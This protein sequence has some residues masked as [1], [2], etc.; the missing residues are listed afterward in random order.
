[1]NEPTAPFKR[2][3]YNLR[4]MFGL[5][6][7]SAAT[8]QQSHR[9]LPEKLAHEREQARRARREG[10][11]KASTRAAEQH[12]SKEKEEEAPLQQVSGRVRKQLA[13]ALGAVLSS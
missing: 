3:I 8:H 13:C 1:V 5:A 12:P 11:R 2:K 9:V 4:G 6:N 7:V 10:K